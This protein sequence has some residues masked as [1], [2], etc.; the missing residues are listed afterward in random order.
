[1]SI[2]VIITLLT[3]LFLKEVISFEPLDGRVFFAEEVNT[4]EH[5]LQIIIAF[6]QVSGRPFAS[7]RVEYA[8]YSMY[9][10]DLPHTVYIPYHIDANDPSLIHL[11]WGNQDY[12]RMQFINYINFM[13]PGGANPDNFLTVTRRMTGV[14]EVLDLSMGLSPFP[15]VLDEQDTED[16]PF[17]QILINFCY[18][19]SS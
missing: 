19:A 10:P 4:W 12:R 9:L 7:V 15:L 18:L 2:R 11:D 8:E 5:T 6:S 13:E 1:M 3:T 16:E 17:H 14:S